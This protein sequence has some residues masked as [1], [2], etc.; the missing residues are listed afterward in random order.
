MIRRARRVDEPAAMT[1][2]VPADPVEVPEMRGARRTVRPIRNRL[3]PIGSLAERCGD[4][5]ENSLHLVR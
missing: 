4:N 1:S 5:D 2:N 3:Q